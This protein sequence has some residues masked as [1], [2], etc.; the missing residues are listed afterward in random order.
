M[1][2]KYKNEDE[3]ME[4]SGTN[5]LL[6][7]FKNRDEYY[8]SV[9]PGIW[10]WATWKRAWKKMDLNV[11]INQ[12]FLLERFKSKE[13]TDYLI[14]MIKDAK[15]NKIDAWDI[16]WLVTM[17][18]NSGFSIIP[19]KNLVTNIGISGTHTGEQTTLHLMPSFYIDTKRMELL[20][21]LPPSYNLDK[22]CIENILESLKKG[23]EKQKAFDAFIIRLKVSFYYRKGL[24]LKILNK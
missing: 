18:N 6:G 7:K 22:I 10:G 9:L 2:I 13:Y 19:L 5:F 23:N 17:V 8:K 15:K 16:F 3:I 11:G 14:Q 20:P 21:P 12:N 1:L 24:L 4:V